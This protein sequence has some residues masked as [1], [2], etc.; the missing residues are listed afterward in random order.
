MHPLG[1]DIVTRTANRLIFGKELTRN[2]EFHDLSVNYTTVLFGG[3]EMIRSWPNFLKSFLMLF[4]TDI[5][6][7]QKIAKKHLFPIIDRRIKEE[8]SYVRAGRG[9]E[10]KKI[11]PDDAIQWVLDVAPADQRRADIMVFRMLHINIAAI[12]TSST[13]FLEAFYFLA[14]FPEFHEE[15]RAEIV[16]VFRE[17][18]QWTKQALTHLVKLDSFLVEALRFCPFTSLKFQRYI[19]KDWTMKDGTMIPKGVFCWGNWAALSLDENVNENPYKF[20]PW[21]MYRKRQEAG[22]A[23]QNQLV[24]TSTTNLTF[25]HGKKAC[26]GRF[27][28]ANEIKVLMTLLIT[29]YDIRCLNIPG[30]VEE[31]RKNGYTNIT[32]NPIDYPVV[33]FKSRSQEIPEDIRLLFTEI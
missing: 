31:I 20:D 17:E 16:Q 22:Q 19:I 11:K 6:N 29:S 7:A 33:E 10:W 5:R 25:G 1:F 32:K 9:A 26:P 30:G 12:H 3:A 24:M 27:F 13:S 23:H 8:D 15:L 28:A 18:K 21:R 4:R 2:R 14:I